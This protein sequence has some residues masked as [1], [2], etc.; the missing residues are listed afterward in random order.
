LP[1]TIIIGAIT[2]TGGA[3]SGVSTDDYNRKIDEQIAHIKSTC[4][5]E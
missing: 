1:T 5:L 4:K 3:T 2:G